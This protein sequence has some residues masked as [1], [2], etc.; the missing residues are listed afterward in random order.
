MSVAQ[1]V[2]RL[3]GLFLAPF[4]SRLLQSLSAEAYTVA[5]SSVLSLRATE[6]ANGSASADVSQPIFQS[7]DGFPC[8]QTK[9]EE[10]RRSKS[11]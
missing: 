2:V 11:S 4:P 3:L 8:L 10:E 6:L 7:K 9:E 5:A 1:P